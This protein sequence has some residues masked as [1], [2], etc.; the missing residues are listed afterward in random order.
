MEKSNNSYT[1]NGYANRTEYLESISE[2]Y[3]IDMDTV[4]ALA[5]LL[6]KE[7][8]FDGLLSMLQDLDE[9]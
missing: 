7:E 1:R 6:G 8:D 4:L 2:D 5:D 3:G 9:G